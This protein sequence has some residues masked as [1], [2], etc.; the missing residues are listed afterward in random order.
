MTCVAA[1]VYGDT[2]FMG[3]DSAGVD[4]G[5]NLTVRADQKVFINGDYIIG[6]TSSF[7]MGQLL[8]YSFKPPKFR[9]D[10]KELYEFMVTNFVDAVRKCLKEGGYVQVKDGEEA[11]GCFL[12]GTQGRLF[13][14]ESDFQ[15]GESMQTFDAVGCGRAYALGAF[16][17]THAMDPEKRVRLALEIAEKWSAGVRGPFI[18]LTKGR[19]E[20]CT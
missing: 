4:G 11:G 7:R 12:V 15:V 2:I 19:T 1:L 8:R 3:A 17:A 16:S 14:I 10:E 18:I 5:F 6:F 9:P 20:K 13:Q